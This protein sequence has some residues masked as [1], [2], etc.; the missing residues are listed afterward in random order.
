MICPKKQVL[1]SHLKF[2]VNHCICISKQKIM[3]KKNCN[4]WA[5][6]RHPIL[7][8]TNFPRVITFIQNGSLRKSFLFCAKSDMCIRVCSFRVA[9]YSMISPKGVCGHRYP[10]TPLEIGAFQ[11]WL[12]CASGAIEPQVCNLW[13]AGKKFLLQQ[14]TIAAQPPH[15]RLSEWNYLIP[16]H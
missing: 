9:L 13:V 5:T 6:S 15:H 12:K 16:G 3:C 4:Y 14:L 7:F 8:W 10:T 11:A 1:L 2:N